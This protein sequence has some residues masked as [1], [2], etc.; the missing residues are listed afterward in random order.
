MS[1]PSETRSRI[2]MAAPDIS[3]RA[4]DRV[5]AVLESGYLADGEA[6]RAFEEEFADYC[7]ADHAVAVANGTAALHAA[8]VAA[9]IGE[10]DTVVTTPFSFVATANA[11]RLCGAEPVFADVDP[12]TLNLDP[13]AVRRTAAR[14]GHVDAVLP[15]HLY[16]LSA[17]VDELAAVA[18][19]HD[20]VL[21]EDAAQAHGARYRGRRVGSIGD[22]GT[23]S[24][25]PT[26]NMTTGEGG[27]VVTDDEAIAERARRFVNHGREGSDEHVSL[28]HNFRL[29]NVAAAIG[30]TQLERLPAFV[31]ARRENAAR[32]TD[33]VRE[34]SLSAPPDPPARR[35]AYHQYTLRT[36]RRDALV[37]HLDRRGVDASVYY[38]T[39][40]HEQPAYNGWRVDAPVAE[41]AAETVLSVPVHPQLSPAEVE[42]VAD[43]LGSFDA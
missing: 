5:R 35:H 1:Q 40:I 7:D 38:P 37:E 11:V 2:S 42:R 9:G 3:E 22:V 39:P 18:D 41:R 8:L 33:V 17:A 34:T 19:E 10:G 31:R 24:F 20:A 23:F 12:E 16:G 27:M 14:V 36:D 29:P 32:L 21:V 25:Y 4:I 30:R 28:G 13:E 15:V 26:K 6:V 43:V